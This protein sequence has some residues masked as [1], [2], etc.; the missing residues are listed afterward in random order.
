M[1]VNKVA[2]EYLNPQSDVSELKQEITY[3]N[4][5]FDLA[6]YRGVKYLFYEVKCSQPT[7]RKHCHVSR[8]TS[9]ARQQASC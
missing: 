8:C 4:S 5:R 6:C 2:D 1:L 9:R 3:G 7:D